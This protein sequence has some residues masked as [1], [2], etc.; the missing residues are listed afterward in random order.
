MC[1]AKN[2]TFWGYPEESILW[3]ILLLCQGGKTALEPRWHFH[4]NVY[5]IY[6]EQHRT[7]IE[8]NAIRHIDERA[9]QVFHY[10][11]RSVDKSKCHSGIKCQGLYWNESGIC[12]SWGDIVV[13]DTLP[14][15]TFTK[16]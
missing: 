5:I 16:P 4:Q 12:A 13:L 7:H 15:E 8:T 14:D 3:E 6:I 10:T 1:L 11:L 2:S 9:G